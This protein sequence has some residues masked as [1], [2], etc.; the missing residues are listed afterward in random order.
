MNRLGCINFINWRC[1]CKKK[2]PSINKFYKIS[3]RQIQIFFQHVFLISEFHIMYPIMLT[4]WSAP[5]T[6]KPPPKKKKNKKK[7]KN[8]TNKQVQFVLPIYSL[9]QG[10]TLHDQA[11]QRK[12]SLPTPTASY[13]VRRATS[14]SLSQC[15][16]SLLPVQ[17]VTFWGSG[18][19]IVVIY[20]LIYIILIFLIIDWPL[21]L[22]Q[23]LILP[24]G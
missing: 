3:L 4:F 22:Y 20:L 12:L 8:K 17:A 15:Q 24:S 11:P 21:Q 6:F 7:N 2:N 16:S 5:Q 10:Q 18:V 14:A 13:Q 23:A 19:E 1:N 9:E